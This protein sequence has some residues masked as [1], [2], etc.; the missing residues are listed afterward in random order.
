MLLILKNIIIIGT[1]FE[2]RTVTLRRQDRNGVNKGKGNSVLKLTGL[3]ISCYYQDTM[4]DD[5]V[6]EP[7]DAIHLATVLEDCVDQLAI[8]GRIMPHTYELRKGAANIVRDDIAQLVEGQKQLEEKFLK[9]V[10]RK[11]ELQSATNDFSKVRAAHHDVNRVGGDLKNST[12]AFA[13]SLRQ[14][15]LTGDNISKIQEDR[16][17]LELVISTTMAELA[18]NRTFSILQRTVEDVRQHKASLRKTIQQEEDGRKRIK[19]LVKHL[20]EI[21]AVKESELQKRS[22]MI[23]HLKDQL[24]EMKA[25]SSMEGKYIKKCA[26]VAV[27][28]TQKRCM[29]S[30][31]ELKDEIERL[32]SKIDDE[33]RTNS[34][35]ESYL[36]SHREDLSRKLEYWIDKFEKDK[37]AKQYE[38][39]V[40]KATKAKDLERLQNLSKKYNEYEQVVLEDRIEKEMLRRKQKQDSVQLRACI[41]IQAFWRGCMVRKGLGPYSKKKKKGKGGKK[42]KK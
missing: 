10:N 42:G 25:K 24:Q 18:Q 16:A 41:K 28:Q 37:D 33:N 32:Q 31:K 38:L 21:K 5:S 4:M 15:P 23:S 40:L 7:V 2:R 3:K 39:D 14:N 29:L 30:E 22:E 34:E 20:A 19:Q 8:L 6:L 13:R 26:D 36:R 11:S 12:Y 35:I 9:T 17:F 27:A 1:I